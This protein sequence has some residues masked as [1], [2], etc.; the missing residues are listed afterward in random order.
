VCRPA[1]SVSG[2][3]YDY[4]SVR[5][6]S[7]TGLQ[8]ALV[9]ADV[10]GKGISAALLMATIQSGVRTEVQAAAES[11]SGVSTSQLV[12]R[13]NRLL[14]ANTSAAKYA[15]MCLAMYDDE[16]GTLRY[17]NAGHL[18]PL[19]VRDGTIQ[20]L[21]VNG[22][23]VGA[24]PSVRYEESYLALKPADLVVFFTDGVT[25]PENQFGEM[26]GE[27]RLIDL[28]LRHTDRS[29]QQ[30]LDAVELAVREWTGSEEL[31]DDLTLMVA[32]RL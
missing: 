3:Y 17:T 15:T 1:R 21:D 11:G 20:R 4:I 9:I 22:T 5:S 8:T 31:Q 12:T 25:E 30:I 14:Y 32:R 6:N 28:L 26:F 2:D 10:A 18:Q 16:T 29:E 19:V 7:V 27:E 24:F 23:I 13:L